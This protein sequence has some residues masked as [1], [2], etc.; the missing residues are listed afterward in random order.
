MMTLMTM[1][2]V[3]EKRGNEDGRDSIASQVFFFSQ[4]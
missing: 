3:G 1:N 4:I 2:D